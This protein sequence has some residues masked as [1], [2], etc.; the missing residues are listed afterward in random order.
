MRASSAALAGD[1][2]GAGGALALLVSAPQAAQRLK[3][4]HRPASQF[5]YRYIMM[6][7]L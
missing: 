7:A 1:D 4:R 6:R 2:A 3:P 5:R